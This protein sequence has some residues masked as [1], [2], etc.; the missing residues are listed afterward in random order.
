MRTRRPILALLMQSRQRRAMSSGAAPVVVR[1]CAGQTVTF[2][3]TLPHW[4]GGRKVFAPPRAKLMEKHYPATGEV[5]CRVPIADEA[6][7]NEGRPRTL[8]MCAC[9]PDDLARSS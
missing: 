9:L 7:V 2:H 5:L 8:R 4:I 6:I 3:E 1:E